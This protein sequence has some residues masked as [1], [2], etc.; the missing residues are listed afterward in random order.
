MTS[1]LMP[2]LRTVAVLNI[3]V[4]HL[5]HVS[6]HAAREAGDSATTT[7]SRESSSFQLTPP[8]R[9][10]T[11]ATMTT[12]AWRSCFNPHRPRGRRHVAALSPVGGIPVSTH[13]AREGG[14]TSS[15]LYFAVAFLFQPTSPVRT[16]TRHEAQALGV[17]PVSTH[18]AREGGDGRHTALGRCPRELQPTPP[19][20]AATA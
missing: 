14:D 19:V 16:A 4:R 12:A 17:L 1:R 2:L 11:R 7:P 13:A 15:M 8:A 9:A 18:A 5:R 3:P 10:A 20:W 6:T